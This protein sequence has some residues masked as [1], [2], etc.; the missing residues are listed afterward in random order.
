[1]CNRKTCGT[2]ALLALVVTSLVGVTTAADPSL[3]GWWPIDEGTGT[4]TKDASG[5]GHDGVFKGEP[6]W[7]AGKFGAALYFDGVNDYVDTGF[8]QNLGVYTVG[9][10]V[11]SPAAPAAA[12]PSGPVHREANFQINWNHTDVNFRAAVGGK[13]GTAWAAAKFGDLQADTW[14]YLAGTFDGKAI[15]AYVNGQLAGTKV[16]AGTAGTETNTLKFGKHAVSSNT[17]YFK[18]TVDDVKVFNRALSQKEILCAMNNYSIDPVGWWKLDETSGEVAADASGNGNDGKLL[19]AGLGP[20]WV[21]GKIGGGLSFD[22]T[23]DYAELPIGSI[24]GSLSNTTVATWADFSNSGGAWQRIFDFGSGTGIYMFLCPRVNTNGT[25]R[26]AIRT[27][28]V[29]EQ[30]VNSPATLPSGWHHVAVVLDAATKK[31]N[32][33]QDGLL[34]GSGATQLL[35]KDMGNTTQNWLGKS[36]WP[37]ALY[38]GSLD[39]FRIYNR[40]LSGDEVANLVVGGAGFG[41]ASAPSPANKATNLL[42]NVTLS[43]AA[44]QL[45]VTHDVYFGTDANA[46]ASATTA[47]PLGVLAS[48]GQTTL[49][50]NAGQLAFGT[51]YYWRVDEVGAAPDFTVY[52]GNVWSFTIEPLAYNLTKANI[53]A[54]ASSSSKD[55]GPEKTIDGSG[56]TKDQ[57]SIKETDMWLSDKAGPQPAWIQYAFDKVYSLNSMLV[58]NSNQQIE[59]IVGYGA[60]HVTVE[61][62]VDGTTWTKLGDFEFAQAPGDPT[63]TANTTVAFNGVPAQFVKLTIND[64]WGGVFPQT[65][66]SEVRFSYIPAAAVSPVPATG[67]VEL[68]GPVALSWRPGRGV[69]SHEVYL[70]TD[71]DSLA[72]VATVTQPSCSVTVDLDKT[73]YWQVVEVNEANATPRWA[74]VIWT[75]KTKELPKD[76]GVANLAALYNLDG[77]FVDSVAGLNGVVPTD[78]TAVPSFIDGAAGMGK[79]ASFD[80]TN[81][82]VTLPIGDLISK[83]EGTTFALWVN[84]SKSGGDWQRIFDFGSGTTIYAFMASNMGGTSSSPRFA[85]RSA[86]VGE[87]ILTGSSPLTTGWHHIAVSIDSATMTMKLYLDGNTAASGTT[88]ILPKAMGVTTQ[89]WIARSQYPADAYYKGAVDDLRIYNR[90]LS[91]GEVMW[92]AGQR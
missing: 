53:T 24:I 77:D 78:A 2:L 23:D 55:M 62:S 38:K 50:Y 66:L 13:V 14:Y 82:Y 20:Q 8:T 81:D 40:A 7:V 48:P 75:F 68:E 17:G 36:Q 22:G 72:L 10:W 28:T 88:T 44:G 61:Y 91:K 43:W 34:V 33:Y 35:P 84:W 64:N 4:V 31:I 18:G 52:K 63:Y 56:L 46:V 74:S 21:A 60:D 54:T 16:V 80:G 9:A 32:L 42:P 1:M 73:Y 5:N 71:K 79:A 65:G 45:G 57:A 89:N 41:V 76:A 25:I 37:D 92:L 59:S 27:A 51:T 85:M 58:W 86:T 67:T 6:N 3:V 11:K 30:V 26:F 90:A 12:A 83:L 39:D 69:V 29:G 70:G 49:T 19:P 87:Q 47:A 15:N